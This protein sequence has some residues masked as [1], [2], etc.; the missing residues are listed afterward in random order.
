LEIYSVNR[1]FAQVVL[2]NLDDGDTVCAGLPVDAVAAD[3]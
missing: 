1:K 2:E 3:D